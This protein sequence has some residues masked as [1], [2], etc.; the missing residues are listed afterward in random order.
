[1]E[2]RLLL[3][4]V[5]RQSTAIFQLLSGKDKT[6]LV[7]WDSFFV[8]DLSL[9]VLNGIGRLNFKSDGLSGEGFNKDLHTTPQAENKM[10]GRLLLDVVVRQSAAIFQLLAGKDKT[11]LVG[12]DSFLVLDLGLDVLDRVGR[13]DFKSDGLS[14][15]CFHEDLHL[16]KALRS[17]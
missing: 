1:M 8:L 12:R 13:L 14:G 6:L 5:V 17:V 7:R 2:G 10:E 4:V 15:K 9:D 3:D 11:L 16:E